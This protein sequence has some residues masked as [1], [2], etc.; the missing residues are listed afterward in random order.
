MMN[1]LS[2][3]ADGSLWPAKENGEDRGGKLQ[4]GCDEGARQSDSE[5]TQK[6]PNS[7]A[8]SDRR[9]QSAHNAVVRVFEIVASVFLIS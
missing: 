2:A 1:L 3:V 4:K 9:P 8:I 6:K 5:T 7:V